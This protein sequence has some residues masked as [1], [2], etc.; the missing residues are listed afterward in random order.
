MSKGD[1]HGQSRRQNKF[2]MVL[3]PTAGIGY[4]KDDSCFIIQNK[5]GLL[6]KV[7]FL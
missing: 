1:K 7:S 4:P 6:F 3:D 5:V 2:L